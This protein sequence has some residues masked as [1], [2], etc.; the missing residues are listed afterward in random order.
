MYRE[1]SWR[2]MNKVIQIKKS[3]GRNDLPPQKKGDPGGGDAE[4]KRRR[5]KII[6]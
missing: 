5:K 4:K 1:P 6:H 2:G 3:S